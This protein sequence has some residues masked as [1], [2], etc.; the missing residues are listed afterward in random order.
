MPPVPAAPKLEGKV[1]GSAP[2]ADEA[3]GGALRAARAQLEALNQDDVAGAYS[4]F[5]PG[6]R[7]RVPLATFRRLVRSHREMFHTEEQEVSTQS[8]SED[9]VLLD[10]HV[11]SDDDEDYVAHFTLV[12]VDG[13]WCVDNLRW[14]IDEDDTHSS[15]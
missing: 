4:F 15:A 11:T 3:A 1:P 14:A 7:A 9:R 12:H 2:S 10:I 6:Y 5:S 13:R 8:Q